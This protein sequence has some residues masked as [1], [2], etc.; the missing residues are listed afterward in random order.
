VFNTL[1]SQGF[2]VQLDGRNE[3][4]GY[5]IREAQL[6][7]IPY[8]LVMGDKEAAGETVSVRNRFNGDEGSRGLKEFST[9]LEQLI[10]QHAVRP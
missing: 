8:M 3:K 2:R 4:M 1:T 7:K 6:Q 10:S 5:K 9:Q